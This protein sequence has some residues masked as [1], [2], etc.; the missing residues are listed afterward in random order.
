MEW[1]VGIYIVVG[2]FKTFGRMGKPNPG[3]QPLWLFTERNPL[4]LAM[5]FTLNVLFWPFARG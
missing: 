2:V 5:F 4:M 1:I 3:D